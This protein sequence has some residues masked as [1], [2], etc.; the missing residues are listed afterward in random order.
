MADNEREA[1]VT[2]LAELPSGVV[3]G[4][5]DVPVL[6][7][8]PEW[9]PP[10][11]EYLADAILAAGFRRLSPLTQL[12]QEALGKL[13]WDAS[14]EWEYAECLLVGDNP[15]VYEVHKGPWSE[16]RPVGEG[17]YLMKRSVARGPWLA[18]EEGTK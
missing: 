9:N 7:G 13:I 17:Y 1:L 10:I 8:L 2:L 6:S 3:I 18:V 12:T 16:P 15:D 14:H 5:Q 11:T 4:G